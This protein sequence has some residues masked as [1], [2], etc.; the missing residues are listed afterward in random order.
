MAERRDDDTSA[1]VQS[2]VEQLEAVLGTIE[3]IRNIFQVPSFSIGVVYHGK[4]VLTRG[5]GFANQETRLV[6]DDGTVYTIASCTKAFTATAVSMS[7]KRGKL[8]LDAPVSTK[9]SVNTKYSPVV[10]KKMTFRD[11]LSHCTGLSNM[12][13]A[14]VGKNGRVFAR[15][16]DIPQVFNHLP[17]VAEFHKEWIYN[18]W[19]YALAGVLIGQENAGL[20]FGQVVK[21]GIFDPLGM[22]RTSTTGHVDDNYAR[23]YVVYEDGHFEETEPPALRDGMAFDSS[24]SARSCV[25]DMLLWA[26]AL[27]QAWRETNSVHAQ[28]T[29]QRLDSTSRTSIRSSGIELWP[30]TKSVD[31]G[32]R[33]RELPILSAVLADIQTPHFQLWGDSNQQY[34]LGLF[35]LNLPTPRMNAIS[36][37]GVKCQDYTIGSDSCPKVAVGHLGE[38]GGY[39]S[40]YWAFPEEDAS[41]VVLC[42]SFNINGDPTNMIAQV[43]VQAMFDLKPPVNFVRFSHDIV[44]ATKERWDSVKEEW[45]S[46]RVAGTLPKVLTAYL[47]TF[48]NEELALDLELCSVKG[49]LGGSDPDSSPL[50]LQIN[51]IEEQTFGLYHYHKDSWTFFPRTR[52]DCIR[53]GYPTYLFSWESFIIDF[54]TPKGDLLQNM[55]WRLDPDKRVGATL[56]TRK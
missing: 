54:D 16:E 46:H 45:T 29:D 43:L 31:D 25:R 18:N 21:K 26:K 52:D 53:A 55:R 30:E 28:P 56:F 14:T 1:E 37:L 49:F 33:D 23:P 8:D 13:Y 7:A 12:L 39:L 19:P 3:E 4:T 27:M 10:G 11:M 6:P 15:H 47:G 32:K 24:S 34:A 44:K 35:V 9:L 22:T 48:V 17:K 2:V 50:R 36:N 38:Y 40:A 42:N 51:R 20:S 41:V 5:F